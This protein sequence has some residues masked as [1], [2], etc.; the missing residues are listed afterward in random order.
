MGPVYDLFVNKSPVL[1]R[2]I[3]MYLRRSITLEG[4]DILTFGEVNLARILEKHSVSHFI[5]YSNWIMVIS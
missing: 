1:S 5:D 3:N 4:C 2:D